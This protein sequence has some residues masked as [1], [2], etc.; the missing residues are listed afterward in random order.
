MLLAAVC[1][2]VGSLP[3]YLA[4]SLPL[5][6]PD[7]FSY[8]TIYIATQSLFMWGA[9]YPCSVLY[10]NRA[11]RLS[12]QQKDVQLEEVTDEETAS[13]PPPEPTDVPPPLTATD[14]LRLIF[15]P[16]VIAV[17]AGVLV[18][19]IVPLQT[20]LFQTVEGKTS[21]F[22]AQCLIKNA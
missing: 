4:A 6:K 1:S 21:F 3:L 16:V 7:V 8:L 13:Q 9:F 17:L 14:L 2:N 20:L 5:Q 18:S 19:S 11:D 22:F 12:A 15:N 10:L